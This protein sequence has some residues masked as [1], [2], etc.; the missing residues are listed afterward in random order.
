[1]I[2]LVGFVVEFFFW[3]SN[4]KL[5]LLASLGGRLVG[6]LHIKTGESH[7][8]LAVFT[9]VRALSVFPP[10]RCPKKKRKKMTLNDKLLLANHSEI[11]S[12]HKN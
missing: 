1:M 12:N 5:C 10:W 9:A 2:F 8:V 6:R 7:T 4:V 3:L 11:Q